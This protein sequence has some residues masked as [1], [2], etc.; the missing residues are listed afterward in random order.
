MFFVGLQISARKNVAID[1]AAMTIC[2]CKPYPHVSPVNIV[3]VLRMF[4]KHGTSAA[5][6]PDIT[7]IVGITKSNIF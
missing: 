6:T 7:V 1:T 5:I 3:P 4:P 2:V